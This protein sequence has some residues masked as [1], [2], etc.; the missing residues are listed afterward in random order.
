MEHLTKTQLLLLNLLITFVTSIATGIVTVTL[1]EKAPPIVTQTIN[2]V[3]EHTIEKIVPTNTGKASVVTE[4]V[5]VKEEDLI[6]KAVEQ[7]SK[8]MFVLRGVGADGTEQHLGLGFVV[9]SDGLAV[10]SREAVEGIAPE[11]LSAMY[12]NEKLKVE[13]L[14]AKPENKFA[15]LKI[16]PPA[17]VK[18]PGDKNTTATTTDPQK[19][20]NAFAFIS[21]SLSDS[22]QVKLGQTAISLSGQKGASV[23]TGIV[24][25]LLAGTTTDEVTKKEISRLYAI[26]T[27]SRLS[28]DSIGAPLITMEGA[29]AGV[30]VYDPMTGVNTAVPINNIKEAI[31]ALADPK[32]DSSS[33]SAATSPKN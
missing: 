1:L 8:S 25:D 4:Q 7:N 14:S 24:S 20:E 19:S 2:R 29:V 26:T 33:G 32:K 18:A 21:A 27:S 16:I 3:V 12:R 11:T 9:S 6:V 10:T 31:L 5:V 23:V 28:H 30:M 17:P 13:V 15:L 22:D